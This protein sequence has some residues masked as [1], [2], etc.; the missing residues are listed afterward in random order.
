MRG[1]GALPYRLKNGNSARFLSAQKQTKMR[2]A[3]SKGPVS[4]S[5]RTAHSCPI[6][7]GLPP[8][9]GRRFGQETY[10]HAGLIEYTLSDHRETIA[11]IDA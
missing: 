3:L 7:R 2:W 4:P 10:P 6:V 1:M 11:A 9:L 5:L 8:G